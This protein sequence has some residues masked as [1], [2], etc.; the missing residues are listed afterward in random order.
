MAGPKRASEVDLLTE[1]VRLYDDLSEQQQTLGAPPEPL[2]PGPA[3]HTIQQIPPFYWTRQVAIVADGTEAD[4]WRMAQQREREIFAADA[5]ARSDYQQKLN[6]INETKKAI[7]DIRQRLTQQPS[8]PDDL[9]T[10]KQMS[11]LSHVDD[12]TIYNWRTK[13]RPKPILKKRGRIPQIFSYAELRGWFVARR[14]DLA[15]T[16]PESYQEAREILAKMSS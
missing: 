15:T 1:L 5:K 9:I 4:Q 7:S 16:L 12:N 13:G 6:R 11:E 10:I 14:H 2:P 8:V 3:G